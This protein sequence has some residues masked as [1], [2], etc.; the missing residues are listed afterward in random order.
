[1]INYNNFRYI[2]PPRPKNAVNPNE[3]NFWDNGSM[4]GQIKTNG[5]NGVI[6]MNERDIYIYNRHGQRMTNHNL[7]YEEL[8]GLYSGRGW[9]VLNGEILNKSKKDEFGNNFNENFIIFDILVYNSEY[10][11]GKTFLERVELL[12]KLYGRRTLE[13]DYLYSIYENIHLIKSF[14]TGFKDIFDTYTPIDMV[15]GVVLKR[16]N[17]K[18][19]IGNTENNNSKSQIK[20]RKSSKNYKF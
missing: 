14:E 3:L 1:M 9:M 6:F 17:A 15:E 18:L 5:S 8:K 2:F 16:K 4:I 11:V 12:E 13:K 20:S 10:L 7:N 19:E